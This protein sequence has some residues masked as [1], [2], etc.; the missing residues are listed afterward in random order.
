MDDEQILKKQ[1]EAS[2]LL[3]NRIRS[4]AQYMMGSRTGRAF[5]WY[6]LE[7]SG[8]FNEGFSDNALVMAR[9]SGRRSSGLQLMQIIDT[10]TPEKYA[11]MAEEAREDALTNSPMG[12]E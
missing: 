2:R 1:A 6:L 5:M 4:G 9:S 7:Q 11:K 12:E 10:F 3:A 8:V